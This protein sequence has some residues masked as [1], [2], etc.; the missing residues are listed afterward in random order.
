MLHLIFLIINT[1]FTQL[2]NKKKILNKGKS[3]KP[4]TK[5]LQ[6]K[7]CASKSKDMNILYR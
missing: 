2:F 4:R 6:T 7:F 1:F 3:I 5:D